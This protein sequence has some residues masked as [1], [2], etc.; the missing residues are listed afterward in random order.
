MLP[1]RLLETLLDCFE[2]RS[3]LSF[4]YL[5]FFESTKAALKTH[6][7]AEETF[8]GRKLLCLTGAGAFAVFA[9]LPFSGLLVIASSW[10]AAKYWLLAAGLLSK[11]WLPWVIRYT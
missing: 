11:R 7:L 2:W 6:W 8:C 4:D 3:M 5:F 1:N 9:G 10:R